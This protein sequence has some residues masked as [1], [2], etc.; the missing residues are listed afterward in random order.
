MAHNIFAVTRAHI[1]RPVLDFEKNARVLRKYMGLA[2][3][4]SLS[5]CRASKVTGVTLHQM[6]QVA[7]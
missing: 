5:S 1:G 7:Q 3:R 2:T 6:L 4:R